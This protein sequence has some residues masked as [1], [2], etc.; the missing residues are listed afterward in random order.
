MARNIDTALLRTFITVAQTGGMTPAARALHLTQA[1]VSQQV[2]RL[3]Q[4][5]DTTL[6]ERERRGLRLTAAG[7]RLL[8]GAQRMVAL[9]DEIHAMMTAPEHAGEVRLGVPI[10]IVGPFMPGILKSFHR[11]APRI[12][13]TLRTANTADLVAE[14]ERGEIDMTL[15]TEAEPI[16]DGLLLVDQ[17]VWIGAPGGMSCTLDPLPI[18]MNG[19]N[20][21]FREPAT[22]ALRAMGRNWSLHCELSDISALIALV[23]ADLVVVPHLSTIVPPQLEIIDR[24]DLLPELP[25]SYINLRRSPAATD[26][27]HDALASH[28]RRFFALHRQGG[29]REELEVHE[30]VFASVTSASAMAG[31]A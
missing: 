6:F 22:A 8:T 31:V 25:R 13:V 24:P 7:E 15:T 29:D 30:P 26:A 10:D 28:I 9:N 1:A 3:E 23:A 12:R 14:L 17:L 19:S 11:A 20:C 21:A 4:M 18:G 16:R 27:H 5:F 2:K